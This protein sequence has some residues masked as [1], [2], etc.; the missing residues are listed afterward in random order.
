MIIIVQ[1]CCELKVGKV[2]EEFCCR[3]QFL[4]NFDEFGDA[5]VHLLDGV[6]LG[7][8]HATLI[9]DVIDA[10]LSFGM[11]ATS[12]THLIQIQQL[13][14]CQITFY[15]EI[16]PQ[17]IEQKPKQNVF[18]FIFGSIISNIVDEKHNVYLKIF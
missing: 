11:L 16:I 15:Y 13:I 6:V 10:T 2:N 12:S 18:L 9:G 17:Q 1:L 7:K 4:L 5:I 14:V 8:T 3:L